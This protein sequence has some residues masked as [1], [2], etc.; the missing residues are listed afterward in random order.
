MYKV[1]KLFKLWCVFHIKNKCNFP[2]KPHF[3]LLVCWF[4]GR[5]VTICRKGREFTL[6]PE[7]L[8]FLIQPWMA[9]LEPAWL[10][11]LRQPG[12]SVCSRQVISFYWNFPISPSIC[13]SIGWSVL[14]WSVCHNFAN[15]NINQ[16][17]SSRWITWTRP[18]LRSGYYIFSKTHKAHVLCPTFRDESIKKNPSYG[19]SLQVILKCNKWCAYWLREQLY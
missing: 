5:S 9:V 1:D 12:C 8:L 11:C 18:S 15:V 3:R 16:T 7:L 17:C 14:G 2:M 13:L 19:Q 4:I 10:F 6:L